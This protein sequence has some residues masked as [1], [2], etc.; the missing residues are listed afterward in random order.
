MEHQLGR[1]RIERHVAHFVD[2]HQRHERDP[3]QLG[4][5]APLALGVE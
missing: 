1:L 3:A 5:E 4:R 2:H